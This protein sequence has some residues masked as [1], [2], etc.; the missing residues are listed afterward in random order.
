MEPQVPLR[1][2]PKSPRPKSK[3]TGR[4]QPRATDEPIVVAQRRTQV[5]PTYKTA[6]SSSR[7]TPFANW[8]HGMRMC[9][10]TEHGATKKARAR[11]H[12]FQER[13][14]VAPPFS[15]SAAGYRFRRKALLIQPL[16]MSSAMLRKAVTYCPT[17]VS[18]LRPQSLTRRLG[19][20]V[21]SFPSSSD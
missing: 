2:F 10:K 13:A 3:N 20:P 6:G 11:W 19:R 14:R 7:A 9:A 5:S 17:R 4:W 21:P 18:P 12:S 15:C 1:Q 8:L 16:E